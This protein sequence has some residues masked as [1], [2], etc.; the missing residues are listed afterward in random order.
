M[1]RPAGRF[2]G[3]Q[4]KQRPRVEAAVR[5]TLPQVCPLVNAGD[6]EQEGEKGS[7]EGGYHDGAKRT[8]AYR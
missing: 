2:A 7:E 6:A 4:Q 8:A 1:W 3:G 5:A